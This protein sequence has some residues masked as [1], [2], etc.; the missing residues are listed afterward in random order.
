M[1]TKDK[2]YIIELDGVVCSLAGN[3]LEEILD[4]KD[5]KGD[6]WFISDMP[7]TI[8]RVMTV[9][10]PYKYVEVMLRKK[11]Q[12]TGEF[13]GPISII[14]HWKKKKGKGV[15]DI[16][17]SAIPTNVYFQ[18]LEQAKEAEDLMMVFPISSVIYSVLKNIRP[19]K[20]VAVIFQ[21]GRSA[22]LLVG[23]SKRVYHANRNVAFDTS[24][25]Q[26]AA[27]WG[28]I[29]R[30]MKG[31][32][33]DNKIEI[34][35]I[36]LLSW[37]DS[38]ERED[39]GENKEKLYSMEEEAIIVEEEKHYLSFTAAIRHLSPLD[40]ISLD[41][42]KALYYIQTVSPY[43]NILFFLMAFLLM[44]G[45][46]WNSLE[47][48]G[49]E[50]ELAVLESEK[51]ILVQRGDEIVSQVDYRDTLSFV[52]ELDFCRYAPTYREVVN[53]VSA[54]LSPGMEAEVFKADYTANEVQVEIFVRADVSFD[55][56]HKGYTDFVN[57]IGKRG[58]QIREHS[59]NTEVR[60]SNFLVK[61]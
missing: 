50:T 12:E 34:E 42:D 14:T 29:L 21:H 49:I 26:I 53:D 3:R 1:M 48:K 18:Y 23:S 31:V 32:E 51:A 60:S 13:D 47:N 4:P 6:K 43:L 16:F 38:Q 17:F 8:S 55:E 40:S 54:S 35:K 58:Y 61:M 24:P 20:P 52:Q 19:E 7:G 22:D 41:Q 33:E 37:I 56:A 46:F 2:T 27:L 5:I 44:G 39:W 25:E 28:T 15:T 45:Y 9:E 59:L 10:A 30:D 11:L 36:V 57:N